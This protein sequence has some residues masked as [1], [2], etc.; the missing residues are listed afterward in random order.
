M[1]CLSSERLIKRA[2]LVCYLRCQHGRAWSDALTC[3]THC[4]RRLRCLLR[5]LQ[6][7]C[8]LLL[9]FFLLLL[10]L[11]LLKLPLHRRKLI[12]ILVAATNQH[13]LLIVYRFDVIIDL[14][15]LFSDLIQKIAAGDV[16]FIL[17]LPQ[18]LQAQTG[19]VIYLFLMVNALHGVSYIDFCDLHFRLP[20]PIK[21]LLSCFSFKFIAEQI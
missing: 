7:L 1:L 11:S 3:L 8:G 17:I 16:Q 14:I 13:L 9:F 5:S 20:L 4:L 21:T 18:K 10:Q 15:T 19:R 2:Q 6:L 12:C